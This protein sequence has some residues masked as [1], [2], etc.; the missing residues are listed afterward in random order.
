MKV[1]FLSYTESGLFR[2]RPSPPNANT[3]SSS[4]HKCSLPR[5]IECG[6]TKSASIAAFSLHIKVLKKPDQTYRTAFTPVLFSLICLCLTTVPI[7][8]IED[9]GFLQVR[10]FVITEKRLHYRL[11]QNIGKN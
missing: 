7:R 9:Q 11:E 6:A 2:S 10:S 5:Q 8:L 4:S 3:E 1:S